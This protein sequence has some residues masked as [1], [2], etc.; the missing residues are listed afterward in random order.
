MYSLKNYLNF[1]NIEFGSHIYKKLIFHWIVET[2]LKDDFIMYYFLQGPSI[3]K[4][5]NY[6]C[7]LVS[8]TFTTENYLSPTHTD[9][10]I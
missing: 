6:F 1:T 9:Y 5:V 8:S 4:I 7:L 2:G 10:M 3:I